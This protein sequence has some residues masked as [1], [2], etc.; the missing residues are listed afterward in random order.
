MSPVVTNWHKL[1]Q[2]SWSERWLLIQAIVLLPV[3]ALWL[4]LW[5]WRST[6]DNIALAEHDAERLSVPS[7][8]EKSSEVE[9]S[10]RRARS[11]A[12]LVRAASMHGFYRASCLQESVALCWLLRRQGIRGDLRIGVRKQAGRFEAHAWVEHRGLVLNDRD[13]V[14]ERFAPLT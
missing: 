13:D 7:A 10:L 8:E 11:T 4:R 5:T 14:S 1:R 2:L 6:L 12:R 9:A 3:T